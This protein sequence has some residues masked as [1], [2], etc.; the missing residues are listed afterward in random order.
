MPL[1]ASVYMG[2]LRSDNGKVYG[3]ANNRVFVPENG[4]VRYITTEDEYVARFDV[5]SGNIHYAR[6][7]S[8]PLMIFRASGHLVNFG[9]YLYFIDHGDAGS[10]QRLIGGYYVIYLVP[11]PAPTAFTSPCACN[12]F[13]RMIALD[14]PKPVA[15]AMSFETSFRDGEM[16]NPASVL[17]C[18]HMSCSVL[19]ESEG[20]AP[21]NPPLPLQ[22]RSVNTPSICKNTA[23]ASLLSLSG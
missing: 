20:S 7:T 21:E 10:S 19:P 18:F 13:I 12:D 9:V 16:T 22:N 11:R 2:M 6:T 23:C 17:S 3:L 1:E 5:R 15:F 8:M 14:F 4:K